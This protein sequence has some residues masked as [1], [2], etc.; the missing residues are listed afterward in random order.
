MW[1]IVVFKAWNITV[2]AQFRVFPSLLKSTLSQNANLHFFLSLSA[3]INPVDSIV[4]MS[5]NAESVW[6]RL[7]VRPPGSGGHWSARIRHLLPPEGRSRFPIQRDWAYSILQVS[8]LLLPLDSVIFF[9]IYRG[10]S[11]II[12]KLDS[13]K[14]HCLQGKRKQVISV[15]TYQ[16]RSWNNL[17]CRNPDSK[18]SRKLFESA[19]CANE[20]ASGY[21]ECSNQ[22]AIRLERIKNQSNSSHSIVVANMC[23]LVLIAG[24]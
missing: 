11:T 14:D 8:L 4:P 1:D 24:K 21:R 20:A 9:W 3:R 18:Q 5:R 6:D 7:E 15:A 23:W 10:Q 16:M 13:Y 12:H 19:T 22:F 17:Y 2:A